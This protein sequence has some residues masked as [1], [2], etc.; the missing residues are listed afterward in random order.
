MAAA[1]VTV[2]HYLSIRVEMTAGL[3]WAALMLLVSAGL[4]AYAVAG[5]LL[6][7]FDARLLMMAIQQRR[8]LP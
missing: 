7:A 4:A 3:R 6:G 8:R 1:L 2:Q 5:H